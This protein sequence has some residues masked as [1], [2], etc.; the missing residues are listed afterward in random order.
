MANNGYKIHVVGP[1]DTIQAIGDV[2]GVDWTQIAMVNG[3]V[4]PYINTEPESGDNY[5]PE[6]VATIGRSLM[7]PE[8]RLIFPV[9]VNDGVMDVERYILGADLDIYSYVESDHN[10][11]RIGE[12]GELL[13]NMKGDLLLAEGVRNL[14]QQLVTRLGVPK[15]TLL[16]HPEYGS[17]IL[18]YI[19]KPIT[20]ELLINV[21]LCI[22]ECL[23]RDSRV[24]GLTGLKA[25]SDGTKIHA[26]CIVHAVEPF[27][28]FRLE[29]EVSEAG[30]A[31][32]QA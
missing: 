32:V 3:L 26:Q 10:V 4:Y 22:Q 17:D 27:G 23:L 29:T 9:R 11:I 16:L 25:S 21:K 12:T 13:D 5:I 19:G 7:I 28:S 15:G 30:A 24:E 20:P 8:G 18:Q 2:Y 6:G 31:V 1:G 14:R